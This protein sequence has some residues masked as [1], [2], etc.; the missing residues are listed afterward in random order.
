MEDTARH[1]G[2]DRVRRVACMQPWP[3]P[4]GGL[5]IED[6][7]LRPSTPPLD[8]CLRARLSSPLPSLAPSRLHSHA[9][10]PQS[11]SA[12]R[13]DYAALTPAL[14]FPLHPSR[15]RQSWSTTP[16]PPPTHSPSHT[17]YSHR[18]LLHRVAQLACTHCAP[19]TC[20]RSKPS[21]LRSPDPLGPAWLAWDRGSLA[22]C[23]ILAH[24]ICDAVRSIEPCPQHRSTY[25]SSLCIA[26]AQR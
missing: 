22:Y 6:G 13:A 12:G 24:E 4:G 16:T 7:K 25:T 5:A 18:P 10:L 20:S 21:S 23:R 26:R 19:S 2:R 9:S 17:T 15:L 11:R 14:P 3:R 8:R 1:S